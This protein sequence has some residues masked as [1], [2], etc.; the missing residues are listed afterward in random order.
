MSLREAGDLASGPQHCLLC[1]ASPTQCQAGPGSSASV[2]RGRRA[3]SW[4]GRKRCG[5]RESRLTAEPQ[6]LARQCASVSEQASGRG[7][8]CNLAGECLVG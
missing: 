1:C 2:R 3:L 8:G 7:V 6:L 5:G 4:G